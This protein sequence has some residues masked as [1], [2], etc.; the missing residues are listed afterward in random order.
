MCL[1]K[2]CIPA[3]TLKTEKYLIVVC[4]FVFLEL[5]Y[6][7]VIKTVLLIFCSALPIFFFNLY[8]YV[9]KMLKLL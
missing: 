6:C 4:L 3:K 5:L 9:H 1:F 8:L 2:S 7:R